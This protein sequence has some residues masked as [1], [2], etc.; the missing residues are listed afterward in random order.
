MTVP[1]SIEGIGLE[2][3]AEFDD[4]NI[5]MEVPRNAIRVSEVLEDA[6][7]IEKARDALPLQPF[8]PERPSLAPTEP[9]EKEDFMPMDMDDNVFFQEE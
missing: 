1:R 4:W 3:V 6:P 5:D 2:D 9:R 8:S 7:E